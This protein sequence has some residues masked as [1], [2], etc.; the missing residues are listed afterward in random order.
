MALLQ[1]R[2]F[3]TQGSMSKSRVEASVARKGG[4]GDLCSD[5]S[6]QVS[7]ANSTL[8]SLSDMILA[9]NATVVAI[10]MIPVGEIMDGH[11]LF[12]NVVCSMWCTPCATLS[13]HSTRYEWLL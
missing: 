4:A 2:A 13:L 10:S 12:S 8:N 9:V 7:K 11:P 1:E 6:A 3:Q 5:A